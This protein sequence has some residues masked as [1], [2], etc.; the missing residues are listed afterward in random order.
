MTCS[1]SSPLVS[2]YL[3]LSSMGILSMSSRMLMV[4]L[5]T[6]LRFIFVRV[7]SRCFNQR[8]KRLARSSKKRFRRSRKEGRE[9]K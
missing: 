1:I 3:A 4:A 8:S 7:S 9:E 5:S 2:K 6:I